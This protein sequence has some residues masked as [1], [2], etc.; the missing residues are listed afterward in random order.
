M[1]SFRL[2]PI[3]LSLAS[4]TGVPIVASAQNEQPQP[5][6]PYVDAEEYN[7][8]YEEQRR[9]RQREE[10]RALHRDPGCQGCG[11][12][13]E[14][15]QIQ[16]IPGTTLVAVLHDIDL[17][18]GILTVRF[19]FYNDG[20]ESAQLAIDPATTYESFF[21]KVGEEKLFILRDDDGNL[22]AKKRLEV[23]LE[24][25]A[26]ESWWA[27]FPAPAESTKTFDLQIP[28]VAPFLNVSIS[29]Q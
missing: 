4:I 25:G 26:M 19:R 13:T 7:R 10:E 24:P 8:Q 2:L 5:R 20:P 27:T 12:R 11:R 17:E 3:L 16:P 1:R 18:D 28:P 6:D 15:I 9:N 21:V 29:D 23:D 22:Q 14:G